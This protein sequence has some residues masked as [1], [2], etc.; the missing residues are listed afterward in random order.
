[1]SLGG[2]TTETST[3][4][5]DLK[6]AALDQLAMARSVGQLGFVPYQ[7]ATVAGLQPGQIA[8]MQNTNTG[9]E[10]FGLAPSA[11]PVAGD[12][13]PYAMYQEQLAKMAP[14]QRAFIDSMFINPMT[15]AAPTRQFGTQPVASVPTPAPAAPVA[16][17]GGGGGGAAAT[18]AAAKSG[19]GGNRSTT[20]IATP[21]SYLPGGVNTRN[22]G[23]IANRVAAALS[24]PQGA[25]TQANRPVARS[26]ATTNPS[27][28]TRA[29]MAKAAA[30][31]AANRTATSPKS[32]AGSS[33]S[34]SAST[35]AAANRAAANRAAEKKAADERKARDRI[36][37]AERNR[38][39]SNRAAANKSTR[40]AAQGKGGKSGPSSGGSKSSGG[41]NATRR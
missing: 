16:R 36:A 19:G 10:A 39:A 3:I 6:K 8:A 21:A 31:N 4:D 37:A 38:S 15:G 27:A 35:A 9:L 24:R 14:G 30:A 25:P 18:A 11:A 29:S 33:S 7:G 28:S 20:S 17:G 41:S 26:V 13:S 2:K 23:S 12:L 22:P 40:D 1:M 34:S 5:P 32:G